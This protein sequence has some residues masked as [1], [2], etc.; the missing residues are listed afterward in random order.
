M[1]SVPPL[2]IR[3]LITI[4]TGIKNQ[5]DEIFPFL[6]KLKNIFKTSMLR[7]YHK[8]DSPTNIYI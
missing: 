7:R 8:S 6:Q 2:V 5:S 1:Q 4:L 3:R